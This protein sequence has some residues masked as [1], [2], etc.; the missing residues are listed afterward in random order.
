[1]VYFLNMEGLLFEINVYTLKSK[2][3]CGETYEAM[4]YLPKL[5]YFKTL[6]NITL[7]L[8][9]LEQTK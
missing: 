7:Y 4:H 1:M 5:K 9:G 6:Q 2:L 3:E 8:A